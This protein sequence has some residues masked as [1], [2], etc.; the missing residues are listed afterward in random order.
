VSINDYLE[1]IDNFNDCSSSSF[2]EEFTKCEE[3]RNIL[4]TK[5]EYDP[6]LGTV[7]VRYCK[8]CR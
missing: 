4:F 7:V 3:C 6:D 1:D 2:Y 5:K 8:V